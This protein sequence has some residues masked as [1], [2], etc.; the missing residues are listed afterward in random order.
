MAAYPAAENERRRKKRDRPRRQRPA[1]DGEGRT[2]RTKRPDP[3]RAPRAPIPVPEG[4]GACEGRASG[5][6]SAQPEAQEDGG[7]PHAP[8]DDLLGDP[9]GNL[10]V[11]ELPLDLDSTEGPGH[12]PEA[13]EGQDGR[14]THPA[15]NLIPSSA[16]SGSR[17]PTS[18]PP[19]DT[20]GPR[21][22]IR[23]RLGPAGTGT[24]RQRPER[25]GPVRPFGPLRLDQT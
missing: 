5:K 3:A 10:Q 23:P 18:T 6:G 21:Y 1:D 2:R 7:D 4:R 22:R 8:G 19:T 20:K 14:T 15:R 16:R 13:Q 9:L 12:H 25:E 11:P 17:R 24:R